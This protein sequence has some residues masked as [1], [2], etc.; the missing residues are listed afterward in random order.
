[1]MSTGSMIVD[2]QG[3]SIHMIKRMSLSRSVVGVTEA[4]GMFGH[5]IWRC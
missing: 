2:G 4:E 3:D 5:A 1:M